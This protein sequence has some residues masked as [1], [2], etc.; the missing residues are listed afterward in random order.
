MDIVIGSSALKALGIV[1]I[2]GIAAL[3]YVFFGKGIAGNFASGGETGVT[4]TILAEP[5]PADVIRASHILVATEDEAKTVI[6]RLKAGEDFGAVAKDVSLC[7]SKAQGG[8]LGEFGRGMMVR[9]FEDAA[10]ALDVGELSGP[11]QSQFGWHVILR[12][13]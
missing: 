1:A 11:I 12:T 9:E 2:V 7:P 6:Q 3:A 10:F 5:S 4:T 8:D 13:A